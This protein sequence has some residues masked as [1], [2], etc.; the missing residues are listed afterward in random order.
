LSD[1][2]VALADD[3]SFLRQAIARIL[4]TAPGFALTGSAASGEELL[5]NLDAWDPEAIILDLAMPGMGGLATL[6]AIRAIR[7]RRSTPVLILSTHSRQGAPQ[8][9]EALHR[10]ATDFL[11]KQRYSLID[12]QALREALVAKL[13]EITSRPAPGETP[14][15][16]ETAAAATA[17]AAA[18][19]PPRPL[20][21]LVIGA[22]TGGP[23]AIE[24]VLRGLGAQGEFPVV[25]VQHM[26]AGFTR[27]FAD[28]LRQVLGLDVSEAADGETL[29]AGQVVIAPGG[30][31]LRLERA[32]AGLRTVLS[33]SLPGDRRDSQY[34]PS[35][36]FLFASAAAVVGDRAAGVLL[37]G[38]GHDGAA[39]LAA[40]AGAGALTLAQDEA[41]SVVYGMP[42][43]ALAA[44]GVREVLPLDAIG[45]R[46]R[47][48]LLG[49]SDL[50]SE[51][52]VREPSGRIP[53][54][55]KKALV[56]DDSSL[57]HK[58]FKLMLPR[59]ELITA[60]NGLEALQRLGENADVEL[61]FLDINM[62]AMNGLEFL[63][64]VKA[65]AALASI[66][67]III[68]TEGKEQDTVR[69]LKGGAAAYIRKPFRNETVMDLIHRVLS[70]GAREEAAESRVG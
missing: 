29:C 66:P 58:M 7:A 33:E 14:R 10:G 27:A 54:Q 50:P 47:R 69:G 62:P 22:S 40:L 9:I 43:A 19:L 30:R 51:L 44:G 46:L 24:R 67:V 12:F 6:D 56:I 3:S 20:E 64:K 26:P 57:I 55:P 23:P 68:S 60:F 59:T 4:S 31:H 37:T 61:I 48:L 21:L 49:R 63:A 15:G 1:L 39:G 18:A 34:L 32:P 42:R 41:T 13:R 52:P 2:R 65:D 35:V 28:R 5:A 16:F 25:V 36:D 38:M 11:D 45:P 70:P 8:T 17:P 53:M